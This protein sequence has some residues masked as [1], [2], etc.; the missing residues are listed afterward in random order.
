M[1]P[2]ISAHLKRLLAYA[3]PYSLRLVVGVI[4]VAYVAAAEGSITFM[5]KVAVDSVLHPE[6]FISELPLVTLPWNHQ[7]IY[8]N[9]FFP[10]SIHHVWTLFSFSVLFLFA[11]KA[12]AE[13][14]GMTQMQYAGLSA[15]RDLRNAFY[16]KVIRQPMGFFLHNPTG[17][18]ISVAMND[19]ERVRFALSDYLTDLFVK[20]FTFIAFVIAMLILDWKLALATTVL[21][22]VVVLPVNK[23]GKKIRLAAEKSQTQMSNLSQ[24]V[25]ETVSGNRVVKAFGMEDF[26]VKK[27]QEVSRR[28]LRENYRLVRAAVITSPLMDLVG[29]IVV[30]LL[31]LYV[32]DQIHHQQTTPGG[33]IAFLYAM[34]NAY[35]PLK[36]LGYVYQQFQAAQG[37]SVQVFAC[38]DLAEEEI[39]Q[40]GGKVLT[41]FSREIVFD[42]MSFAYEPGTAPVLDHVNFTAE[43]GQVIALV[44]SSGAGKTTLVN[45]IPRF[46]EV[47]SG[48]IKI[49]GTNI[50]E[51]TLR[52]LR[53]QIA[54]VT[55]ENILF[56]DT[57]LN[58]ICYGMGDVPKEKVTNAAKAALAHDFILELPKGYDTVIG[59]RGTRLSGGQ[60]QRIAI[61]RAILKDSPILI[62][63]EAT[64]EL[65]SESE[66]YV[67]KALGNLMIGRTAFVIAH[68][69]GTV[70][71]A[72]KILVLE[73][74]RIRESGT[75]AELLAKG[76]SY[77]RLH[78]LQ[79]ADDEVLAPAD[80]PNPKGMRSSEG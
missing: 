10:S 52:S 39:D 50:R 59:E 49:D 40:K 14:L 28:L 4:L 61:A 34:F 64:S 47:T 22:P 74:G 71:K 3:R 56:H 13:Y 15:I 29:A 19:I 66:K 12:I 20:S 77:A 31:V 38:L 26:E 2:L 54:M 42:E 18:I 24:I 17:R 72:D 9:R 53:N 60:R 78:D 51:V 62:L 21:L 48:S 36:R 27:F 55:Q 44:G 45:L 67:Q 70:R 41:G 6:N 79:F 46:Y 30:P 23:L 33:F 43:K 65:D 63:D 7:T 32:R 1:G 35:M 57:V 73:D 37:A 69:L 11:S 5:V 76:G 8:L 75:H 68:R 25:E 58:N 80:V 16:E